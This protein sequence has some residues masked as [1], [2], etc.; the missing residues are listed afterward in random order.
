M[1]CSF[2]SD[3]FKESVELERTT[4]VNDLKYLVDLA[5]DKLN[6]RKDSYK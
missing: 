6:Y 2:E 4:G 1:N 3:L 5:Y